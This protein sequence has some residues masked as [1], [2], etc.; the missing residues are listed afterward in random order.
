MTRVESTTVNEKS[1]ESTE[2]EAT[3]KGVNVIVSEREFESEEE[4]RLDVEKQF[5]IET[6]VVRRGVLPS[7]FK[8]P[9]GVTYDETHSIAI[10]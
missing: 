5:H 3:E 8:K 1:F 6:R 10:C 2:I 7:R 9:K 4:I